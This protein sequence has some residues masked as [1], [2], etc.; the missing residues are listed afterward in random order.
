MTVAT[1]SLSPAQALL[2]VVHHISSGLCT[3]SW[4]WEPLLECRVQMGT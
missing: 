4:A 2:L 1:S 3:M